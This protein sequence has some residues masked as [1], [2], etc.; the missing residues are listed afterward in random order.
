MD[1]IGGMGGGREAAAKSV[2][3]AKGGRGIGAFAGEREK[4]R[5]GA[6]FGL[7]GAGRDRLEKRCI[8]PAVGEPP[9]VHPGRARLRPRRVAEGAA[10][11]LTQSPRSSQRGGKTNG[12]ARAYGSRGAERVAGKGAKMAGKR[13]A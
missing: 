7:D 1:G 3:S 13:G 11:E 4:R 10:K 12:L 9:I 8:A 2:E 5:E 6:V